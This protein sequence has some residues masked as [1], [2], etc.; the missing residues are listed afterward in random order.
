MSSS[1]SWLDA[2]VAESGGGPRARPGLDGR[3]EALRPN[4]GDPVR[5]GL[6]EEEG[7]RGSDMRGRVT[8]AKGAGAVRGT[9]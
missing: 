4:A 5:P 1:D 9:R 6:D 2:L 3:G 7:E 8:V